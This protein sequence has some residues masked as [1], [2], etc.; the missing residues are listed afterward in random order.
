MVYL[1]QLRRGQRCAGVVRELHLVE[2]LALLVAGDVRAGIVGVQRREGGRR[3][4]RGRQGGR[5]GRPLLGERPFAGGRHAPRRR[6]ARAP[7]QTRL[8]RFVANL[9][10]V[11]LIRNTQVKTDGIPY[12]TVLTDVVIPQYLNTDNLLSSY[13]NLRINSFF[14]DWFLQANN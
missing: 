12:F 9:Q 11:Q 14:L 7:V 13:N 5:Q 4:R 8:F 10:H 3:G 2:A 1:E 6:R